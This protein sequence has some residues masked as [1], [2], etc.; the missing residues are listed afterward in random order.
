MSGVPARRCAANIRCRSSSPTILPTYAGR[1]PASCTLP[2][3]LTGGSG[4]TATFDLAD[5]VRVRS[6][7]A[8]VIMGA[9]SEDDLADHLRAAAASGVAAAPPPELCPGGVG[10]AAPEP[11]FGVTGAPEGGARNGHACVRYFA[12]MKDLGAK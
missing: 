3:R 8:A 12:P 9:G 6:L 11:C 7:Y 2:F 1:P 10:V 4:V 5:P